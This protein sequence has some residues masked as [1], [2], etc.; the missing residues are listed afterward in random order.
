MI[1]FRIASRASLFVLAAGLLAGATSARAQSIVTLFDVREGVISPES[2]VGDGRAD[3]TRVRYTLSAAATV[4]LIVFENDGVTPVRT[5]RPLGTETSGARTFYWNG[6]RDDRSIV[7]EGAYVVRLYARGASNPDSVKTLPVYV[8]VTPPSIQIVSV[9]PNPYA[10]G[11][12]NSTASVN[13]SFTIADASPVAPG[14]VADE[15]KA[16]F[17]NPSNTAFT[18]VSLVTTPAYAG[19]DGNYVMAWNATAETATPPDGEYKVT[20][21]VVDVAGYTATSVYHFDVDTRAPDIKVTSLTENASVR[22][23][24]DSLRGYAFDKRGVDSLVVRYASTRPYQ[25]VASSY[26][27]GDTLRFAIPLADSF[28]TEGLHRVDFRAVDPFG[29]ANVVFFS[30]RYDATAP[31]APQLD[32]P[33]TSAWKTSTYPLTG[34]A[35]DGGDQGSFVR[36]YRNGALV[37]SVSTFQSDDFTVDVPLV[38]GRN[39]IFTRLRD[40][41]Q[42]ASAPSNTVTVTFDTGSGVFAPAPFGPGD[43]FDVNATRSAVRCTLRVFDLSGQV[44]VVLT[45]ESAQQFY[46][47]PWNGVNG[48][49][50]D[51]KKGPLV[52]VASVDYDDGS[53]DVFRQVFLFD[54]NAP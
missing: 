14:R 46:A 7:P 1:R 24:P 12:P 32:R 26:L 27:S 45:D 30:F 50:L 5:L 41:A 4:S 10:P 52:A 38:A 13:I 20:L 6:R 53:H 8:D 44:V 3:S 49:G 39:D 43:V 15:L 42:N 22:S 16:A 33:T 18:P 47:I 54:P 9:L 34:H 11:A 48:S 17:T 37:D 36:V 40:S 51:V 25:P 2:P 31:S 19:L 29:R 28:A 21:T 35:D 23:V